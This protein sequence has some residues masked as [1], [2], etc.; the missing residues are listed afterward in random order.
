MTARA[1]DPA[2][3]SPSTPVVTPPGALRVLLTPSAYYPH[4]GGI[5]EM[6]RQLALALRVRGHEV[7]VLTNRWPSGVSPSETLDAIEITRLTFPLPAARPIS[8]ARFLTTAV[9]AA[10]ALLRHIG[11]IQPDVVHVVGAGPP[12]VYLA[13]LRPR[14]GARLVFTGAGELT[15]DAQGVF[16][17]SATLRVG[18]RRMLRQADAVTA[19]SRYVLRDIEAFAEVR[20]P[21]HVVP[22][23]VEPSD[24]VVSTTSSEDLGRYVLAIGRLVPQKGFDVLVEAFKSDALRES[25]LVLAGDGPERGRLESLAADLGLA[26][27][28]RFLGSVERSRLPA[29]LRGADAFAFPSRGEGFGIALLEAMAAGVPAVAAAAGGVPEFAH[30]GDN[31]LLV[32]PEDPAALAEALARL[33]KEPQLRERLSREGRK[34]AADLAWSE[35]AYR[36]EQIYLAIGGGRT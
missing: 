8:A 34:T 35:I 10:R 21:T 16:E 5:E 20:G 36:Y 32:R 13:A 23:G 26:T 15:F 19:C 11:R 14:L 18:L 22:N 25:T 17:R 3:S 33:I 7:S 9:P 30:D 12:S 2:I 24:F 28:V 1:R 27:R 4:I 29:L 6:T 31:A